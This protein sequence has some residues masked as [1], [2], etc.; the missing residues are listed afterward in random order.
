MRASRASGVLGSMVIV[1]LA[2]ACAAP[3]PREA[4]APL[5]TGS[6]LVIGTL[7][8]EYVDIEAPAEPALV[9]HFD[10]LDGTAPEEYALPVDV[11][12]GMQRGVFTGALPAGVYAFREVASAGRRYEAGAMKLPFQVQAGAVQDAGHYAL[13]PLLRPR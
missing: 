12:A 10:R 2:C 4:A 3:Q 9:V 8:Y 1:A 6:G 13:N 11:D 7:S 5:V